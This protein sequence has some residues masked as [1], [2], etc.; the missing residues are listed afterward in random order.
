MEWRTSISGTTKGIYGNKTKDP[1]TAMN[2]TN[3]K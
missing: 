3:I 2:K 1:I